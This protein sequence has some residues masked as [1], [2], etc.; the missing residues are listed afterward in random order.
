MRLRIGPALCRPAARVPG[1]A[2][3][4][5]LRTSRGFPYARAA[6]KPR[7]PEIAPPWPLAT[8]AQQLPACKPPWQPV[9]GLRLSCPPSSLAPSHAQPPYCPGPPPPP[10]RVART[11]PPYFLQTPL[12]AGSHA[13]CTAPLAH[14]PSA[15]RL[16]A[17]AL[18]AWAMLAAR[19][20]RRQPL[21]HATASPLEPIPAANVAAGA[22]PPAFASAP[23]GNAAQ[24][25]PAGS[26][27]Q[28]DFE[29]N[30]HLIS[31][32]SN[33]PS[34]QPHE[35]THASPSFCFPPA[36]SAAQP[37][38]MPINLSTCTGAAQAL[39]LSPRAPLPKDAQEAAKNVQ[40]RA[41]MSGVA[42]ES[43]HAR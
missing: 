9:A 26:A 11:P 25:L 42:P 23:A 21:P 17:R 7:P 39:S 2:D 31:S 5:F 15:L 33:Q 38:A 14:A 35:L 27:A 30:Y 10:A 12:V 4:N 16:P 1:R 13:H 8:Y 36:S 34:V 29:P 41:R 43:V 3:S 40:A 19:P 22:F 20:M 24:R 6:P 28:R 32:P 37:S 18:P